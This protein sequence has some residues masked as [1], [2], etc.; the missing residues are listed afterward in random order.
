M[1]GDPKKKELKELKRKG[2]DKTFSD[3]TAPIGK[4]IED[5]E[6]Y[7][8]AQQ[9]NEADLE[10]EKAAIQAKI[11][12]SKDEQTSST[13]FASKLKDLKDPNKKLM[14]EEVKKEEK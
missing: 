1:L 2:L 7:A 4:M 8:S 11:N 3:I 10:I 13:A 9:A 14:F 12:V 5:L 6:G